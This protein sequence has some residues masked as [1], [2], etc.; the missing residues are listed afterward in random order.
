MKI[1]RMFS[2][3]G[4]CVFLAN[5]AV[6]QTNSTTPTPA[7]AATDA[8]SETTGVKQ[9]AP[10][11]GPIVVSWHFK[12]AA[13]LVNLT[14]NPDGTYL[15]SGNNKD[16]KPGKDFDIA[17]GLKSK[18]GGVILFHFAGDAADGVQ[19]SKQGKSDILKENFS[20][21]AGKHDYD[22][23]YHFALTSEGR[24]KLYEERE[25]KKEELQKEIEEAVKRHDEKI[26][27]EKK[28]RLK[29]EE[30]HEMEEVQQASQ[31]QSSGGSSAWS[32]VSNL[33]SQ[34]SGPLMS[35]L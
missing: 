15:F 12:K 22:V 19:W 31:Q 21:F 30:Q 4:V 29:K 9:A 14:V 33:L 24:A 2:S 3:L 26:A 18:A 11:S 17:L 7:P 20:T 23:E 5:L 8:E 32:T 27:A 25:K 28:E 34:I 1:Y 16:K 6:A 13:G 10:S 35:L